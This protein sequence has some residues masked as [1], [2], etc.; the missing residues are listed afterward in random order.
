MVPVERIELPTLSLQ[1]RCALAA[2][3]SFQRLAS[4]SERLGGT[5]GH[6]IAGSLSQLRATWSDWRMT[7]SL[8]YWVRWRPLAQITGLGWS[9]CLSAN[10]AL[11]PPIGGWAFGDSAAGGASIIEKLPDHHH[12]CG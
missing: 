2:P 4:S 1:H 3:E 12:A 8:A 6:W 9:P 11:P 5:A 10:A 7:F